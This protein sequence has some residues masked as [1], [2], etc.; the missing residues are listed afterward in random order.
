M[1]N[2][3]ERLRAVREEAGISI[4]DLATRL[5]IKYETYI[6]YENKGREPKQET[7]V[8]IADALNI[9]TDELLRHAVTP[10]ADKGSLNHL[11]QQLMVILEDP[12]LNW[13]GQKF[14]KRDIDE[15]RSRVM[16]FHR[17]CKDLAWKE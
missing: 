3:A 7:L 4:K 15:L 14:N 8:K 10:K 16:E 5:G 1:K 11:T 13:C 17:R 12:D 6:G 2:F 9:T